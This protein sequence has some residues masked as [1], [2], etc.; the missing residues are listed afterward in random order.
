MVKVLKVVDV[1]QSTNPLCIT[2]KRTY[3]LLLI[4]YKALIVPLKLIYL[5]FNELCLLHLKGNR[6]G[7]KKA[8]KTSGVVGMCMR[9]K[10]KFR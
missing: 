2:L 3:A 9:K 6:L 8:D 7:V 5:Q 1:T 4:S 10:G